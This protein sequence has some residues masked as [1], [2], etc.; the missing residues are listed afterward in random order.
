MS[1]KNVNTL[2]DFAQIA[3]SSRKVKPIMFV[4]D[5]G[6]GIGLRIKR[7]MRYGGHLRIIVCT[8]LYA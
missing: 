5:C 4:G 3:T 2:I 1:Y 6:L 7:Y 8:P